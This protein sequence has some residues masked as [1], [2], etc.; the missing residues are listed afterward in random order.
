MCQHNTPK[1]WPGGVGASDFVDTI[2]GKH[3]NGLYKTKNI[4]IGNFQ[5]YKI[6]HPTPLLLGPGALQNPNHENPPTI[7]KHWKLGSNTPSKVI[8]ETIG[9]CKETFVWGLK[10]NKNHRWILQRPGFCFLSW[11]QLFC[12]FVA[13]NVF[14]ILFVW[15]AD[16]FSTQIPSCVCLSENQYKKQGFQS[17]LLFFDNIFSAEKCVI[18]FWAPP[19]TLKTRSNAS[20]LNLFD[21]HHSF[22]TWIFNCYIFFCSFGDLFVPKITITIG[23]WRA[24]YFLSSI[25]Q[26]SFLNLR[27]IALICARLRVFAPE[28]AAMFFAPDRCQIL[29]MLAISDFYNDPGYMLECPKSTG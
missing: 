9:F 16:F 5:A 22:K 24:R 10:I 11:L 29:K 25:G 27:P 8:P 7:Y 23:N 20:S 17:V 6:Q 14:N 3:Q 18:Q 2:F 13:R 15:F 1:N 12:R 26:T 28:I 4:W 21:S 19:N